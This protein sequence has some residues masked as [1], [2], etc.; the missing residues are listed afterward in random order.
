MKQHPDSTG[1]QEEGCWALA[2][3]AYKNDATRIECSI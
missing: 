2:I 3:V 1:V